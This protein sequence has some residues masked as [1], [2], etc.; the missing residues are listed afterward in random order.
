MVDSGPHQVES[1]GFQRQ[2]H[3]SDLERRRD[4]E[5]SVHA[6]HTTRS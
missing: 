6:T 5:G 1:M 3:G 2:D 4:R